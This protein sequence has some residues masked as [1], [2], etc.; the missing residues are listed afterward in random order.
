MVLGSQGFEVRSKEP[1]KAKVDARS[2]G[3]TE[4]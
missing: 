2:R 1:H 4:F 3:A